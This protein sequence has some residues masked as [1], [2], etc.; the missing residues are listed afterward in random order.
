MG[1]STTGTAVDAV[2]ARATGKLDK[3]EQFTS[4]AS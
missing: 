1:V 3:L 2:T 4:N